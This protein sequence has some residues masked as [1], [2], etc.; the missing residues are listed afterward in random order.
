MSTYTLPDILATV[1]EL[2][3]PNLSTPPTSFDKNETLLES[4]KRLCQEYP[5]LES[6]LF[7]ENGM[8]KE[9]FLFAVEGALVESDTALDNN[10]HIEIMIAA[11]G[12]MGT[13]P[14]NL[15][16]DEVQR[17]VRHITLPDVGREGQVRLKASSVLVVGTG[18]LGSPTSLYLAA[19]GVGT[20]GLIDSDVVEESNLQRQVVHGSST[21]GEKKVISA[22]K[23]LTDLNPHITIKAHDEWL[24]KTNA[25]ELF[26]QYDLVVDGTDNFTTRYIA[27]DASIRAGIPLVFGSVSRFDGQV[28]VFNYNSGPCYQCL[29]PNTPPDDLAP[30]CSAGGVLGIVPG[31]VGLLQATEA[32]KLLLGLGEPLVGRLLRYD[33]L[34]MRFNEIKFNRRTDCRACA[35]ENLHKP[36]GS[37]QVRATHTH[38]GLS[39]LQTHQ[40]IEPKDLFNYMADNNDDY[41][42]LDVRESNELEVCRLSNIVHLPLGNLKKQLDTLDPNKAHFVVCHGGVRAVK[43]SNIMKDA[44]FSKVKVLRGGMKGWVRDVDPSM[45]IY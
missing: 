28:S 10:Q 7:Y 42:L 2:S 24:S 30:S 45:P 37:S 43:A 9:H 8:L 35:P 13:D 4:V 41:V 6:H 22:K 26:K 40:Y 36:I 38:D 31:A 11:S 29:F 18:G 1:A 3:D 39:I 12:G 27:N 21:I 23:R 19:A 44:G 15:S 25:V 17:Y 33:A 14:G 32:I 34:S 20:L 5:N 16:N